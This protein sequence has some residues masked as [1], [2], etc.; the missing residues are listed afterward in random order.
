MPRYGLDPEVITL[1]KPSKKKLKP[2]VV[3]NPDALDPPPTVQAQAAADPSAVKQVIK[4]TT[5]A[6]GQQVGLLA[7]IPPG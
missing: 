2:I 7:T 6:S 1:H 5:N 3:P 4:F